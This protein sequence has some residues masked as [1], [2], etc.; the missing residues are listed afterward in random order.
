MEG[1]KFGGEGINWVAEYSIFLGVAYLD[2]SFLGR[3][4]VVVSAR[5][6]DEIVCVF[7]HGWCECHEK[8]LSRSEVTIV[9][10]IQCL[11][12]R[13][14]ITLSTTTSTGLAEFSSAN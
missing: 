4:W 9:W 12:I 2:L 11:Q 3:L 8:L 7:P 10:N 5:R 6:T 1:E 13:A 14:Y